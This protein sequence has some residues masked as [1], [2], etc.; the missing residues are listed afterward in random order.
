VSFGG[1]GGLDGNGGGSGTAQ[2]T[3]PADE[4]LVT[5][6]GRGWDRDGVE[7]IRSVVLV[8]LFSA[9]ERDYPDRLDAVEARA[10]ELG[11]RVRGRFVQRRGV[12]DGG[13]RLMG[14]PLSRR[15]V[16]GSGKLAEVVA[17][18]EREAVDAVVFVNDLTEY[19]RRWIASRVGRPVLT[20][21]DLARPAAVWGINPTSP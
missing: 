20:A 21:G 14:A 13:A 3:A 7:E 2:R 16:I 10:A 11:M 5:R 17:F 6:A 4:N 1:A 9:K 8:G 12:S 15:F 18:C 19:Q